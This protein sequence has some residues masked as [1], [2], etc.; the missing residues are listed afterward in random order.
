MSGKNWIMKGTDQKWDG[1]VIGKPINLPHKTK[2]D[3]ILHI[4]ETED[5]LNIDFEHMPKFI[6]SKNPVIAWI[7]KARLELGR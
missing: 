5:I 4:I 6:N 7:A 2:D 3:L 1:N